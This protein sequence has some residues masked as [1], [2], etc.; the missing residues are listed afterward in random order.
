MDWIRYR[1][2]ID[3]AYLEHHLRTTI[4]ICISYCLCW[5]FHSYLTSLSIKELLRYL[6]FFDH[7]YC[8]RGGCSSNAG[9]QCLIWMRSSSNTSTEAIILR[10]LLCLVS[11]IYIINIS[12]M[13][14]RYAGSALCLVMSRKRSTTRSFRSVIQSWM[15]Y[16]ID[17]WSTTKRVHYPWQ[18]KQVLN[19]WWMILDSI[20]FTMDL[21]DH[22]NIVAIETNL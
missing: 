22:E 19:G 9:W 7:F 20:V 3:G 12:L 1:V 8:S 17:T 2:S 15:C 11:I 14:L 6:A 10:W 16:I 18:I 4:W 21:W 13:I 5:M